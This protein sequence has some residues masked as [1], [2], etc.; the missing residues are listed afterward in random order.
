MI[1]RNLIRPAIG[2]SD[3]QTYPPPLFTSFSHHMP[4]QDRKA[5]KHAILEPPSTG[6][7][8]NALDGH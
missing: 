3:G 8:E 6:R 1:G 5:S 4:A 7:A 2:A